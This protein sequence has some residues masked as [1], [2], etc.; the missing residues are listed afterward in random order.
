MGGYE[1]TERR[2]WFA[3]AGASRTLARELDYHRHVDDSVGEGSC[4]VV[5]EERAPP[6]PKLRGSD[7]NWRDACETVLRVEDLKDDSPRP[8]GTSR[9]PGERRG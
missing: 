8:P 6:E 3:S 4:G 9:Q 1:S 7:D 5:S 2:L